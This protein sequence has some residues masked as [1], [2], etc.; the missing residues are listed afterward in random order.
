MN[1]ADILLDIVS[2]VVEPHHMLLLTFENGE[3]RRFDMSPYLKRRPWAKLNNAQFSQAEV[4]NGTVVWPGDIDIAPEPLY[5][6]S[7]PVE[8]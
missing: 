1:A 5:R 8:R 3:L 6:N 2:V 4:A 7:I